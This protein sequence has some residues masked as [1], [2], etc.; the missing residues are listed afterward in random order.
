MANSSNSLYR[1]PSELKPH[2][3]LVGG[4]D[5]SNMRYGVITK[6]TAGHMPKYTPDWAVDKAV[7]FVKQLN[8]KRGDV[9][10][11]QALL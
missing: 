4:V 8:Q 7:A 10:E 3:V 5:G 6:R 2:I 9:R 1:L 11:V